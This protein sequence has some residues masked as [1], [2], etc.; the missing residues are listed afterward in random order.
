MQLTDCTSI[1]WKK[2]GTA[3]ILAIGIGWEIGGKPALIA[4][5]G[6]VAQGQEAMAEKLVF[7]CIGVEGMLTALGKE[8]V[9][10]LHRTLG[11]AM[12][13]HCLHSFPQLWLPPFPG[14]DTM[15]QSICP[16]RHL[17]HRASQGNEV[18]RALQAACHA[19]TRH[20]L[21]EGVRVQS[22]SRVGAADG[23]VQ[24]TLG[25]TPTNKLQRDRGGKGMYHGC[26]LIEECSLACPRLR[27]S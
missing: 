14:E 22:G 12:F 24:S 6:A 17:Y 23:G 7:A 2:R 16:P 10:C 27:T 19:K 18:V 13:T 3:S 26:M 4:D 20:R 1:F 8:L 9:T 25:S 5:L 21:S 11:W 15:F